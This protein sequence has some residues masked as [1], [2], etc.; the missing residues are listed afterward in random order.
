MEEIITKDFNIPPD[1]ANYFIRGKLYFHTH[2]IL[3]SKDKLSP[4]IQ[5]VFI[6]FLKKFLD[7]FLAYLKIFPL[8]LEEYIEGVKTNNAFLYLVNPKISVINC[9]YEMFDL[10][11]LILSGGNDKLT[12]HFY[13]VIILILMQV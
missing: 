10:V 2:A 7:F 5:K 3:M 8:F 13:K 6:D 1:T 12:T 9:Y 11:K 4:E